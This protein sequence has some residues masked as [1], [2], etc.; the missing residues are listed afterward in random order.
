MGFQIAKVR[1]I[2]PIHYFLLSLESVHTYWDKGN[3]E[4]Q[5]SLKDNLHWPSDQPKQN[6][7]R[8]YVCEAHKTIVGL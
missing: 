7:W 1:K 8:R 6:N 4:F 3:F 5:P 2:L